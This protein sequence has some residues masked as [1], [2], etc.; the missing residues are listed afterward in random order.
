MTT[1][2]QIDLWR[3]APSENQR[4]EFKEAKNQFD[5][6]K[7]RQ[8]CVALANEGGGTLLLGVA[9]KPPR[10]VVGSQAFQDTVKAA[11]DLFQA[12][13]FRVDIEE[14]LH[15]DGRVLVFHIPSRPRGTT[16][17]LEGKYLMRAGEALVP[18]SEDQLRRIFAEGE[19]D[20]LEEYS[21]AD[22]DAQQV[23]ELLDVQTF[24]ELLKLPYPTDRAGVIDRLLRERLVDEQN[25]SYAI[26]RLGALLLARRLEDFPDIARKAPRVVV[27]A[28]TSKLE[29]RLDQNGVK[30]Y[31]VGFQG[32]VHFVM[33]QL[34]QNEV[35]EDALRKAVKLVPEVVIRELAANALVH[36]DFAVGGA[37]VM[38]E[39]Y[40]NRVEFSNPGE[41]IVPVDRFID[42]YQS[43]N[44]RLADLMRRLG[45]CE[46][47]SS[48]ID[49]VIQAAE[50]YQLPAPDFRAAHRRTVVILYG[51]K[52][53]E[54]MDRN[55]RVRA[56]YQHCALRWVMSEKMTNQSLR[57][58]FHLAE[59]KAAIAS[60]IIAA[61]IEAGMIKSDESVGK[62]RK[63]ARY[64]P[65]WA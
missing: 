36:Q 65:F 59:D 12:V 25:G 21:L 45:I 35:I 10:P 6:N 54:D 60:Q 18:M 2:D 30:G 51:P 56:C 27:Y 17:H 15:P 44:E 22:L 14:V 53:F 49:R 39:I 24:F 62:S 41:P 33:N 8:Y 23:V 64:L 55:D 48:G 46:E 63:Y 52:P 31:A 40:T 4:L 42:G 5:N 13:G 11:Q 20:W 3:R 9:D 50:L 37:S 61:A 19:P 47:K 58:R 34:P 26:R 28:G 1:P 29:T 43:R 16:Y 38:I 7:L 32:L 57:E